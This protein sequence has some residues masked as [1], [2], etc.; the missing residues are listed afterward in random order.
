[1]GELEPNHLFMQFGQWKKNKTTVRQLGQVSKHS[2]H[3]AFQNGASC[4][5]LKDTAEKRN[6]KCW[7]L[8]LVQ[9]LQLHGLLCPWDSPGK[10]WVGCHFLLQGIFPTQGSNLGLLHCDQILY[11]LSHLGSPQRKNRGI[12]N[13][14]AGKLWAASQKLEG[15]TPF[16]VIG[17]SH[18]PESCS[19]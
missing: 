19:A 10:N 12:K 6:W 9:R 15:R 4:A 1:M 5:E 17:I 2:F 8:S 7:S 3:F 11:H 18:Y 16:S 13:S 14:E